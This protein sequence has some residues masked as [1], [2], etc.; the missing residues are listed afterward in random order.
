MASG[1]PRVARAG[2]SAAA[3]R[4]VS[5][6]NPNRA[7]ITAREW[8]SR[9]ANK[10]VLRPATYGPCNASYVDAEVMPTG[11]G[12]PLRRKKLASLGIGIITDF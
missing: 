6:A 2:R 4:T 5:S 9:K 8:S 1:T 10:Y 3:R 11:S 12:Q 7:A